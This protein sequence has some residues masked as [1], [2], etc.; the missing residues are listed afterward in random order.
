[1]ALRR[2][3]LVLLD[4]LLAVVQEF[5][6]PEASCPG[7]DR[8][9]GHHGVG[10]LRNLQAQEVRPMHSAFKTYEPFYRNIDVKYLAQVA[11]E[12]SSRGVFIPV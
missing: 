1:M 12:S 3:L 5:L 10:I 8:C 11:N 2:T 9:L 7:L 4:D 6:N